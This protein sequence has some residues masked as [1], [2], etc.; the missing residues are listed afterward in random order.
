MRP[1][2]VFAALLVPALV[3]TLPLRLALAGLGPQAA[4]L[5]AQAVSGSVW[6]GE[7]REARWRSGRLGTVAVRVAPVSLLTGTLRVVI[8]GPAIHG[9]I[10]RRGGGGGVDAVSGRLPF[11]ALAGLPVSAFDLDGVSARFAGGTCAQAS[12][13][14]TL[15][16]AGIL[17][18][19]GGLKGALRCDGRDVLLPLASPSGLARI[20]VRI[21]ADGRYRAT[22]QIDDVDESVRTAL[23]SQGFSAS[24]RGVAIVVQGI[25]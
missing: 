9:A 22:L 24:P 7:L 19:Q 11:A 20:D 21:A 23:V 5:S 25:L 13:T 17:A 6:H 3:L 10:V 15:I 18:A 14:A 4:S 2:L 8:D 16:P 1:W 12:G